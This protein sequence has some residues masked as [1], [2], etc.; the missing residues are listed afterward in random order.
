MKPTSLADLYAKFKPVAGDAPPDMQ[1]E[2]GHFDVF[3]LGNLRPGYDH[4]PPMPFNRQAFYKIS[5]THGRGHIEYADQLI[6]AGPNTLFLAT[7]RVPYRWVPLE[8]APTGYFC[9]FTDA[10]L[11]PAKGG[12]L[13]EELPVFQP[14]AHPVVTLSAAECTAVETIFRKMV[15]EMNSDYV[16]K[17]DL[18]RTYLVE[19]IHFVQRL[20]PPAA[21][22]LAPA[23]ARMAAQFTE[24]LEQQFPLAG[25]APTPRLRT[26]K[27]Y[28]DRLAV[29]VN[30]LNRVLK[31]ATG[32]TTTTLIGHRVAQEAKLL[33]KQTN[34]NVSEVADYLG[35]TD[36]AHF[37][38]FF[39]RHTGLT[40]GDFRG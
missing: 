13:V 1:R 11:L 7:P 17:Y 29:H 36:V 3:S 31:D 10:F 20:Q 39:K 6:E 15:Q 24:L 34:Q 14:G 5:L 4:R 8:A 18:L 37:C 12:V 38:T 28:A 21:T 9:I 25:P 26:A 40:P 2:L 19:L 35:F 22:S 30:H 16:Y 27:D 32:H 23:A 33:L